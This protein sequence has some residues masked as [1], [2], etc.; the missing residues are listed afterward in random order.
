MM[1]LAISIDNLK[2]R[3]L[4]LVGRVRVGVAQADV[5]AKNSFSSSNC[6]ATP[7]PALPTR[8]RGKSLKIHPF[9]TLT[10]ELGHFAN[11][12]SLRSP[13]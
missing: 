6:S 5:V 1:N 11:I 9:V 4:P 10:N 13:S 8:G 7:T 3:S 12:P 2:E